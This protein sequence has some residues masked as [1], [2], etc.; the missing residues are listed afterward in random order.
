MTPISKPVAV[1]TGAS[2][3]TGLAIAQRLG[4]LNYHVA[5]CAR[6]QTDLQSAEQQL[7]ASGARVTTHVCDVANGTQVQSLAEA[8][9]SQ[10]GRCDVLVNNAGIGDIG[11]LLHQMDPERWQRVL[12]TNLRGPYLMLRAFAPAM[13]AAGRGDI[14]NISSLAGKNPLPNGAAYAASKW[15]LLGMMLSA[16]EELRAHG[17]RVSVVSPG[18]IATGLGGRAAKDDSWKIAPEDIAEIVAGIVQQSDRSFISEVLVRPL[19]KPKG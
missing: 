13:I 15:G 16:A 6:S 9:L 5:L 12:D 19:H 3:G 17:V 4:R 11:S 1:I 14:I 2:R 8:V 10:V 18:S 7:A